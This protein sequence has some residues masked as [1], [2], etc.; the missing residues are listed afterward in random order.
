MTNQELYYETYGADHPG[1]A[2]LM[3]IHGGAGT[4]GAHWGTAI[5]VLCRT[6]RV[7]GVELQGHGH[8]PHADR[9]YT[10]ENSAGDIIAVIE[11]LGV[12]PVDLGAFSSGGPAAL[13][14]AQ[15]RPD[16]IRRLVIASSF[17]RRDGL[18]EGFWDGFDDANITSL[19][20][21]LR[22]AYEEIDADPDHLTRMFELDVS[23]MRGF[24]DIDDTA[25]R[26]I[27]C[28]TLF[29]SGR[30]DVVL[31][32]HTQQMAELVPN[33]WS[34]I[35]PSGHGDYLGAAETGG[36]LGQVGRTFLGVLE[37]FLA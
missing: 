24:T 16:L 30:T 10:F 1:V 22:A 11:K 23:L 4:I 35:L 18:V 29:V 37:A 9:P 17:C 34:L 5:P 33:G 19:P 8:T 27:T 6:R 25:M 14:V 2:P 3:L 12:G 26:A 28:P 36:E 21:A 31:P 20:P 32:A 7:I 13:H 15:T